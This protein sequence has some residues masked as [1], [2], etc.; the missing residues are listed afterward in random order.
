MKGNKLKAIIFDWAGTLIDYGSRAPTRAF[1]R[2]FEQYSVKIS[3]A[4][5]RKFMGL[6]KRAHIKSILNLP[7]VQDYFEKTYNRMPKEN[8]IDQLFQEFVPLQQQELEKT[9]IIVGAQ[10][11]VDA[12]RSMGMKIGTCTGYTKA[13]MDVVVKS[14]RQHGFEPDAVVCADEVPQARP[15]PFMCYENAIRMGVYPLS[16]MVKV[17]DTPEDIFEGL[18]AGMWTIGLARSGNLMGLSL[19][20]EKSLAQEDVKQKINIARAI[21][22]EAG[23]HFVVDTVADVPNVIAELSNHPRLPRSFDTSHAQ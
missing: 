9:E 5:V 4:D 17:G 6:H 14:V 2:L 22:R 15:A 16:S 23:A 18:N 13:M 19:E 1:L 7:H 20:E 3:P 12:C 8:D 21:L 10:A 11:T